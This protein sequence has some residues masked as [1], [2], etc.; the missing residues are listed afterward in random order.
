MPGTPTDWAKTDSASSGNLSATVRSKPALLLSPSPTSSSLASSI[1]SKFN[2]IT[3][4]FSETRVSIRSQKS[5]NSGNCTPQ[6]QSLLS[7][8][9]ED[10]DEL[11]PAR[12]RGRSISHPDGR[13]DSNT[14]NDLQNLCACKPKP[15]RKSDSGLNLEPW[16]QFSP[17]MGRLFCCLE[18]SPSLYD[19]MEE[20]TTLLKLCHEDQPAIESKVWCQEYSRLL[21]ASTSACALTLLFGPLDTLG[22]CASMGDAVLWSRLY[23]SVQIDNN[24]TQGIIN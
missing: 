1:K 4:K 15:L 22:T 24:L 20:L 14:N 11:E 18:S 2:F 8:N 23:T 5:E 17:D 3:S 12:N 9:Y 13:H 6:Q 10:T 16:Q 7:V 21:A 19:P